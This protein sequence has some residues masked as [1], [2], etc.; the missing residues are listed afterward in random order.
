MN[1]GGKRG[2]IMECLKHTTGESILYILQVYGDSLKE[3]RQES[4]IITFLFL[5]SGQQH[6][7]LIRYRRL[8][9][10]YSNLLKQ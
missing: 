10:S 9:D 8:G 6:Q 5:S 4:V 2:Q 3:C 1:V 7:S